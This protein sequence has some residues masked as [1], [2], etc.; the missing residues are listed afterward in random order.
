[1]LFRQPLRVF[2]VYGSAKRMAI[3]AKYRCSKALIGQPNEIVDSVRLA[4]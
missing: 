1:M 2:F 3:Y 4:V